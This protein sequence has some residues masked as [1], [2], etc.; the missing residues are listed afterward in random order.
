MWDEYATGRAARLPKGF[1]TTRSA[2]I[3]SF[4]W[5]VRQ[6]AGKESLKM[7]ERTN[8]AMGRGELARRYVLMVV[9]LFIAAMGVA[10]TRQAQLGVSPTSSVANV[11]SLKFTA[12]SLGSWLIA[13]NFL[14]IAGQLLLLRSRFSPVQLLQVPLSFLFGW[15]T[16]FGLWLTGFLPAGGYGMQLG[17]VLLGTFVLAFGVS[18]S[19]VA[20]VVMNSGEAFVKALADAT[21]RRFG[22][23]KIAFDVACVAASVVLSLAFFHLSARGTREGTLIAALCTGFFVNLILRRIRAPLEQALTA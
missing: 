2:G 3:L 21:G 12:V 23:L 9:S 10:L 5:V 6:A 14:L 16:D 22:D 20:G 8:A 13:W 7:K 19:V 4:F 18:L 11:V 17:L 15:F 1:K